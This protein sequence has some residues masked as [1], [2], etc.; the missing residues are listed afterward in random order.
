VNF[1]SDCTIFLGFKKIIFSLIT[2]SI[3][4]LEKD[5]KNIGSEFS[6]TICKLKMPPPIKMLPF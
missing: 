4:F 5:L 1:E 3:D 6:A 2:L